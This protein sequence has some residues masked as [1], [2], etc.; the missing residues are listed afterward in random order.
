M[1]IVVLGG[2]GVVGHHVVDRLRGEGHD[3][4]VAS[5]STGVDIG[6]GEGLV[7]ALAGADVVIDA[8][9]ASSY[10]TQETFDFFRKGIDNILEAERI[11]GVGHHIAISVVGTERIDDSIYFR[12][13]RYQ[14][15]RIRK[16]GVPFSI[17]HATQFYEFLVAIV[18]SAEREQI[19]ELAPAWIEPV[20]AADVAAVIAELASSDPLLGSLEI[21]GP[22]RERLSD[23]IR[24]FV[25]I[26]EAPCDV[27]TI[28]DAPY[29]GAR[30]KERVLLPCDGARRGELGFQAWLSQSEFARVDW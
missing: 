2:K 1:N 10:T 26:M 22:E 28:E 23:L 25:T 8:T 17:V 4:T 6:T 14:D 21:G 12:G 19:V 7:D 3:V 27:R 13:K 11:N 29:F 18:V 9:N 30:V 20:A 5:R 24:R 15:E 16:S